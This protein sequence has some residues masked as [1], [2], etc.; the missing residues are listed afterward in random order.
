[1]CPDFGYG[2]M[3][4]VP[5]N[6]IPPPRSSSF[7]DVVVDRDMVLLRVVCTYYVCWSGRGVMLTTRS[8]L[9]TKKEW[10]IQIPILIIYIY[11]YTIRFIRTVL[12]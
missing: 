10:R 8:I 4:T 3:S 5:K 2:G 7:C 6:E 11:I 9:T 1:M 12:S